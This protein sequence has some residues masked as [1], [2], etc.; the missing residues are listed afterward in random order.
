M[1]QLDYAHINTSVDKAE[2]ALKRLELAAKFRGKLLK[3]EN[4]NPASTIVWSIEGMLL[5]YKITITVN[6]LKTTVDGMVIPAT[7]DVVG[8]A[9]LEVSELNVVRFKMVQT[10]ESVVEEQLDQ[11]L[12]DLYNFLLKITPEQLDKLERY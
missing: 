8:V 2:D 1:V 6:R 11:I 4:N 5:K 12:L 9:F 3:W 7:Y 10:Q